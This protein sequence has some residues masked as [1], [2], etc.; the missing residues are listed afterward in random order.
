MEPTEHF[1]IYFGYIR[2]LFQSWVSPFN[3]Q[4]LRLWSLGKPDVVAEVLFYLVKNKTWCMGSRGVTG[5][6]FSNRYNVG[7]TQTVN[8]QRHRAVLGKF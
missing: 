6:T 7:D 5:P 4:N 2:R 3:S 1:G 8:D